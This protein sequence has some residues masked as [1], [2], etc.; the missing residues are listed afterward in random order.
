M[1]SSYITLLIET[2]RTARVIGGVIKNYL[3]KNRIRCNITQVII[4]H[5]LMEMKGLNGKISPYEVKLEMDSITVNNHYNFGFLYKN[6]YVIKKSGKEMD[7]DNRCIFLEVTEKGKQFYNDIC[8]H[9]QKVMSKVR[10]N[11]K[12][13]DNKFKYYLK[14]LYLLQ[15]IL[16]KE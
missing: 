2:E 14:Q 9:T 13:E 11:P 8:E 7:L 3:Y 5:F 1:N 16:S 15:D 12:W 10:E 4:L 6:G